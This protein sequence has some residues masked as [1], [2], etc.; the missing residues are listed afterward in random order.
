MSSKGPENKNTYTGEDL[1]QSSPIEPEISFTLGP[2][3]L[4]ILHDA[5]TDCRELKSTPLW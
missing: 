3:F 5:V 1:Q 2:I 4:R